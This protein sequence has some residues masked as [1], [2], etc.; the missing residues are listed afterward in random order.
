LRPDIPAKPAVVLG[1]AKAQAARTVAR[2]TSDKVVAQRVSAAQAAQPAPAPEPRPMPAATPPRSRPMNGGAAP[3]QP[4]QSRQIGAVAPPVGTPPT[5]ASSPRRPAPVPVPFGEEPTRQVDDD[6]LTALRNAPPAKAAPRPAPRPAPAPKP[7]AR[8]KPTLPPPNLVRAAAPDEETRLADISGLAF[9]DRGNRRADHD[10]DEM[11]RPAD[12][13]M[14]RRRPAVSAAEALGFDDARELEDST[15][16]ASLDGMAA[17]ERART[18][19]PANDE[20]TRAVNIRNDPS[21][22]DIDW[23]LD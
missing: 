13:F 12:D 15:R 4:R 14:S 19:N 6:L 16:M 7:S 17:M 10:I 8:P 1:L 2:R 21:I 22:S 23:D 18:Q 20:R 11:T 5:M 9:D 3:T